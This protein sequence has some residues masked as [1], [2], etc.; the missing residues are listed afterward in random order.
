MSSAT[1][2]ML[3][4]YPVYYNIRDEFLTEDI[5][6]KIMK[7]VKSIK[8]GNIPQGVIMIGEM[9]IIRIGEDEFR[10]YLGE[11]EDE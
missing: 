3:D 11:E 5:K 1:M 9:I 2:I 8:S 6:E 4:D 7:I 10:I